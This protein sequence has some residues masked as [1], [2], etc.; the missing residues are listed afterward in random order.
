LGF[1]APSPGERFFDFVAGLRS[2]AAIARRAQGCMSSGESSAA[3][4]RLQ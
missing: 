2:A 3:S 1:G 4:G